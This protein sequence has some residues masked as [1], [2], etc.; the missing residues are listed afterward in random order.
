MQYS[1]HV[2]TTS[3]GKLKNYQSKTI[4]VSSGQQVLLSSL[5]NNSELNLDVEPGETVFIEAKTV[6]K[7]GRFS[8]IFVQVTEDYANANFNL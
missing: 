2:N 5:S 1:I 6:K 8:T 3:Y 4:D 7:G